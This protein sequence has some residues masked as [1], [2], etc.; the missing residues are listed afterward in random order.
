MEPNGA[1][2]VATVLTQDMIVPCKLLTLRWLNPGRQLPNRRVSHIIVL[3]QHVKALPAALIVT[4][5]SLLQRP[6]SGGPSCGPG[7]GDR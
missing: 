7:R 6:T 2:E 5:L 4:W 1:E 3:D